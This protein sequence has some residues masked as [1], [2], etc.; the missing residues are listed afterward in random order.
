MVGTIAPQ[1]GPT[2]RVDVEKNHSSA[3][4]I[5]DVDE[6]AQDTDSSSEMKQDGVKQV[7]AVTTVWSPAMMW[8]VFG[9]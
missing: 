7:E 3:P 5:H 8:A 6:K 9:L 1:P 2:S 4:E